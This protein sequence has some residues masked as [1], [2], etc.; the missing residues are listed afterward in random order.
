MTP[1]ALAAARYRLGL[2]LTVPPLA[3]PEALGLAGDVG[4]DLIKDES[5]C[6]ED[7]PVPFDPLHSYMPSGVPDPTTY[8]PGIGP[9]GSVDFKW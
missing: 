6:D 7:V 3:L 5:I 4:I 8:G 2:G 9:S 1:L